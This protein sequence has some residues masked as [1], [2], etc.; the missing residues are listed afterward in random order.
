MEEATQTLRIVGAQRVSCVRADAALLS[1]GGWGDAR[2]G[3]GRHAAT[4]DVGDLPRPA[5][6]EDSVIV[7]VDLITGERCTLP[8]QAYDP[9]SGAFVVAFPATGG[10]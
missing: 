2:A 5:R 10:T 4:I 9:E 3:D 7:Q 8:V 1:G 6:Q